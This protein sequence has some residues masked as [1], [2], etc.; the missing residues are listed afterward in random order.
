MTT[1]EFNTKRNEFGIEGTGVLSTTKEDRS[2]TNKT[3]GEQTIIPS[4]SKVHVWFS[5]K[6]RPERIFVQYGEFT[7]IAHTALAHQWL[8]GFKKVPSMKTLM[9]QSF[10]C[11][12]KSVTGKKVEPDGFGPDGSPSWILVLGLV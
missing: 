11:I 7:G 6:V 3:T 12:A 4:G 1:A 9:K 10:D 8:S 2:W 5:P